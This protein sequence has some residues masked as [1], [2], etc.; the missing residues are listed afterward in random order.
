MAGEQMVVR[1]HSDAGSEF[2][3]NEVSELLNGNLIMQTKT[4]GYD[5]KAN[6]RAEICWHIEE[7]SNITLD[8][9]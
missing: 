2:W 9:C 4:V 3:N 7:K 1:F 6:G 5:P 8:T